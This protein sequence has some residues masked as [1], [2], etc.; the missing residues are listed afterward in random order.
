MRRTWNHLLASALLA[1]LAA[2]AVAAVA[3]SRARAGCAGCT[4]GCQEC[5]PVCSGIWDEK[6]SSKPVYSMKCEHACV[7]GRDAWHAPP[8][9]CRC[10]PP[11]GEVIVKKKFYKTDGPEKVERVPKYEVKMV[12]TEPC[13]ATPC[14]D[15]SRLCW[16]NP[17]ALLHRCTSWW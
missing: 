15:D 12:P 3:T 9:E 17:V 10:H 8:P 11:C 2:A 14:R 5:V 6:K 4:G 1:T 13:D 16:W 7:R